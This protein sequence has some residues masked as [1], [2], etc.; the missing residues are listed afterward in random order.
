MKERTIMIVNGAQWIR[1]FDQ[2][3]IVIRIEIICL[4]NAIASLPS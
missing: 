3:Q 4:L 2:R 1:N